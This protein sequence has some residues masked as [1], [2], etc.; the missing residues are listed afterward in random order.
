MRRNLF[1]ILLLILIFSVIILQSSDIRAEERQNS[2]ALTNGTIIDGNGGPPLTDGVVV[3][4][5]GMITAVGTQEKVV[6]PNGIPIVNLQGA[7]V[8]PGFIN[9]HVHDAYDEKKL[10]AWAYAG[11]TTVRDLANNGPLHDIFAFRDRVL[12]NP[13][14]ARLVTAGP[15]VT[16]ED[17]YPVAFWGG[18][19]IIVHSPE[20]AKKKVNELI[21]AGADL[22]KI[23]LETGG[24]FGLGGINSWP[25]LSNEEIATIVQ[26]AHQRH[27]RVS[28]HVTSSDQLKRALDAGV[29]DIAHL[30]TNEIRD[31]RVFERMVKQNVYWVTTLELFSGMRA[32]STMW[33]IYQNIRQFSEAGGK[34][35][36]GTDYAGARMRFELGM[37]MIEM[38]QMTNAG[39]SPMQIIVA[40]TKNAAYVCNREKSLGTIEEGKLADILIVD[41]D[42]LKDLHNLLKVKYVFRNG[43]MI[44]GNRS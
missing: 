43:I 25:T 32:P 17:G 27:L 44:R 5:N 30:V 37:P 36:L 13:K 39:L 10:E 15:M 4:E 11:V 34:V 7:T 19:A 35:V 31:K 38:E 8:L 3:F 24:I 20:D 12:Q 23:P 2:L 29:D 28:V 33:V 22:V 14:C 26:T 21:D 40:A 9:A 1:I 16:V 41:G 42:P 6:I 18:E